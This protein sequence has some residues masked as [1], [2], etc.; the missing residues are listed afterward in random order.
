MKNQLLFLLLC[1]VILLG[2]N[3]P[4]ETIQL[5]GKTESKVLSV[6]T[7]SK[8]NVGGAIEV[9]ISDTVAEARIETDAA[10]I[11]RLR[12]VQ[13]GK[14]LTIGYPNGLY[15]TGES[16]HRVWIPADKAEL[17]EIHISGASVLHAALHTRLAQIHL[18]G[19]SQAFMEGEAEILKLYLSGASALYSEK[20]ESQYQLRVTN[21]YGTISGASMAYLHSDGWI[22]TELSGA[23]VLY[24]TGTAD[25]RSSSCSGVSMILHESK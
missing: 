11:E 9:I 23:S 10:L 19:S 6:N 1:A 13:S 18:S 17:S 22:D 14:N 4:I 20:A 12:V 24:Y 5:T 2:C 21:V 8:L 16:V 7:F 3:P 15:W 25:T